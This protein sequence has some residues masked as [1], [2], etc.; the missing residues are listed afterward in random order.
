MVPDF[1]K[2]YRLARLVEIMMLMD[3][4]K[5]GYISDVCEDSLC[6]E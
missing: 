6:L 4:S 1:K 5:A 2:V 3:T